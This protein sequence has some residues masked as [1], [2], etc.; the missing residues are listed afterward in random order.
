MGHRFCGALR[1]SYG[2]KNILVDMDYMSKWE[3]FVALANNKTKRV[4]A[5]L[6]N[7]I[8]SHFGV[9]RTIIRDVISHICK[10]MF[11]DTL[12]NYVVNQCKVATPFHPKTSGQ[13]EVSNREIKTI[14]AKPINANRS[15][16]S[17][18]LHDSIL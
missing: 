3:N 14:Q 9:P 13:V 8:F 6:R 1:S 12:T 16:W 7:N 5:F 10:Q 11:K 17:I 15:D 2:L 18:K 4:V